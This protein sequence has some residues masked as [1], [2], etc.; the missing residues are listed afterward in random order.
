MCHVVTYNVVIVSKADINSHST[1][2]D[3]LLIGALHAYKNTIQRSHS[4][5]LQI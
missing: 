5:L 1:T 3:A 2:L 4:H